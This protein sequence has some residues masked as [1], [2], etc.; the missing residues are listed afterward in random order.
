MVTTHH[1]NFLLVQ[2]IF[3][4][5]FPNGICIYQVLAKCTLLALF[6]QMVSMFNEGPRVR[7]CAP[8]KELWVARLRWAQGRVSAHPLRPGLAP[9][10]VAPGPLS[11]GSPAPTATT[12]AATH[13][14]HHRQVRASGSCC[15]SCLLGAGGDG[16]ASGAVGA[17]S[18]HSHPL[19]V[20]QVMGTGGGHRLQVCAVGASG[21]S[22]IGSRCEPGW[23][24]QQVQALGGTTHSRAKTFR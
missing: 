8:W 10:T 5:L 21:S 4:L 22:D 16:E 19:R 11:A 24:W 6:W 12:A 15:P 17:G 7:I 14:W 3:L 18:H 2:V 9:A 1:R 23:C 13:P 20:R